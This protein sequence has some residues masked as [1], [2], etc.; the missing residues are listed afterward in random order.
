MG[1]QAQTEA[2][3]ERIPVS[4][5]V[6]RLE[7]QVDSKSAKVGDVVTAKLMGTIPLAD[8]TTLP[9]EAT[10]SGH[11][12]AVQASQNKSD[13]QLTLLF[14]QVIVKGKPSVPVR[15]RI[16][17]LSLPPV[18]GPE[19]NGTNDGDPRIFD[20]LYDPHESFKDTSLP[21]LVEGSYDHGVSSGTMAAKG[22]NTKLPLWMQLQIFI[23][24]LSPNSVAH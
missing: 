1:A 3:T 17:G 6:V 11:V 12:V 16:R 15:V 22:K 9:K 8:G 23:I 20:G 10:L 5:G 13:S 21:E 14:D 2:E 7:K 24:P 18:P 4:A 19:K